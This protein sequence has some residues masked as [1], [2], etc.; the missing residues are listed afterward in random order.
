VA[1]DRLSVTA[2]AVLG[3]LGVRPWSAYEL[4]RQI[5]RGLRW[6]WPRS[7]NKLYEIPKRLAAAGLADAERH[8]AGRRERTVYRTTAAGRRLIRQWLSEPSQPPTLEVES[9]VRVLFAEQGSQ[10][11]LIHTLEEFREHALALQ[12]VAGAI[13]ADYA[14][15]GGPFPQRLHVNALIFEFMWRYSEALRTWADWAL[16]EVRRWQ[17]VGDQPHRRADLQAIYAAAAATVRQ[18]GRPPRKMPPGIPAAE[19][20]ES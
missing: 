10:E 1:D 3:L 8:A 15:T 7:G 12:D 14:E 11:Q 4:T 17:G 6:Y 2:Y 19:D 5:E 18:R 9:L 20:D 13:G 16:D